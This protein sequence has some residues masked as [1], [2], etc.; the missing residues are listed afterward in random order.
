M[1]DDVDLL[2]FGFEPNKQILNPTPDIRHHTEMVEGRDGL[3]DLGS[4]FGQRELVFSGQFY[5]DTMEKL[6]EN[7]SQVK[8]IL[9]GEGA[10]KRIRCSRWPQLQWWGKL[11]GQFSPEYFDPLLNSAACDVEIRMI[12]ITRP[13]AEKIEENYT[14]RIMRSNNYVIIN[15][16]GHLPV[17]PTIT[18][19]I[20]GSIDNNSTVSDIIITNTRRNEF[21][22]ISGE[23]SVGDTIIIDCDKH[24]V[25]VNDENGMDSQSGT[26][27]Q[28]D[29]SLSI[30]KINVD[31]E[32]YVETIDTQLNVEY[33][34][35]NDGFL[36]FY[37]KFRER[38]L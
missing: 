5:A 25:L 22:K 12:T 14:G 1:I 13:F 37:L 10:E 26:F 27:F 30:S 17:F 23:Y 7:L 3:F 19:S 16:N 20:K 15:N 24:T 36:I 6:E 18:L 8:R 35:E 11:S 28:I 31:N 29:R 4:S 2:Q 21:I 9:Y 32:P 38:Y 33:E 34:S